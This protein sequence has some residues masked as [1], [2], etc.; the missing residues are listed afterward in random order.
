MSFEVPDWLKYEIRGKLE[1]LQDRWEHL[2]VRKW[3][4]DNPILMVGIT[5]ASVLVLLVVVIWLAW[6][7]GTVP[8]VK[9]DKEWFYDLRTGELFSAKKGLTPP[10]EA[11]SGPLPSGAAAGVRAY[12]LTYVSE[13][14]ES[15]RFIAFLETTDPQS[16]SAGS[17]VVDSNASGAKQ[18]GKG[19]LIRR[20]RDKQWFPADSRRGRAIFEEAFT[21]NENGERPYYYQPK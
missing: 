4:N 7:E 21:P 1:R 6:P 9:Y 17:P 20:L 5:S 13:P 12:V 11:P 14:N 8:I 3:V 19:K 2:A 10:I 15:E 18:W 16:R